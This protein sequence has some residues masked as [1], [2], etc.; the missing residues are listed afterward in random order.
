[1]LS[2]IKYICKKTIKERELTANILY[3]K[4]FD[5][6]TEQFERIKHLLPQA[7]STGR[8]PLDNYQTLNAIFWIMR[9]G[10][11]WR[12]LPPDYGN[13]NSIY[14]KFRQWCKQDI[15]I[16]I[17]RE[18]NSDKSILIE[19]DSTYCK[20]H[21]H[22]A[23]ARKI[24][25]NQSIGV[26]R[27]GKN[28]KIHA[29]INEKFELLS[30]IL[31]G[32]EVFDS[33]VAVELLKTVGLTDKTV[34]AD[35]AYGSEDIR[36]Y[37]AQNEVKNCIPDKKNAQIRHSFDREVYKQRN[38]VERFFGK[39]KQYRHIATRYDKLSICFWNFIALAAIKIQLK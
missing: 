19:I 34:L 14:H 29:L 27:G 18:L 31:T 32:G 7:K 24:Y 13:W 23:G 5:I 25:G 1:M 2:L 10:A 11:P 8:P 17:L 3:H 16:N 22:A 26:S 15:F 33:R 37:L 35:R 30:F 9:S 28:T 12:D 4:R 38:I 21:Q 36:T 20:V 6:S 39:I